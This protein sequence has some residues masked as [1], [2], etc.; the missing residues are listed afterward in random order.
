MIDQVLFGRAKGIDRDG[1]LLVEDDRRSAQRIVAG[2]V[3]P[4]AN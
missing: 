2:D 3:I 1:A 4:V